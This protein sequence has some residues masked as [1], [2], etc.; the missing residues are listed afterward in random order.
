MNQIRLQPDNVLS[1]LAVDGW[2]ER[3]YSDAETSLIICLSASI[4]LCLLEGLLLL[5]QLPSQ[6]RALSALIIHFIA[7]ISLFKFIIDAHPVH[8]F[9]LVFILFSVPSLLIHLSSLLTYS[10]IT[11]LFRVSTFQK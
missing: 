7:S 3:D 1:S 11:T 6:A 5:V 10:N 8:H 4:V 9:W 2:T